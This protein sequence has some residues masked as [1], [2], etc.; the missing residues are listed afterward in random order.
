[1]EQLSHLQTM[2]HAQSK[3]KI[4]EYLDANL[5]QIAK[6]RFNIILTFHFLEFNFLSAYG[7]GESYKWKIF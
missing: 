3:K 4:Q 5:Q 6:V 1:M 2:L 7:Y